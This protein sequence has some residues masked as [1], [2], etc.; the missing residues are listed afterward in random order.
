MVKYARGAV[1]WARLDPIEGHEQAGRRPVIILSE[2]R[3]N[4][5]SGMVIAVPLTSKQS[6]LPAPFSLDAGLVAGKRAWVKP[7]QVRSLSHS[8]LE[9]VLGSVPPS[10]VDHCLDAFLRVCGR[11]PELKAD[12]DG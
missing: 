8:R 10:V 9:G 12:N 5:R 1:V 4:E 7:A 3:Y 6:K 2:D 11:K